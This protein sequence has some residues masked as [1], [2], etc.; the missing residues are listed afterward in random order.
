MY[1]QRTKIVPFFY[2]VEQEKQTKLSLI[3]RITGVGIGIIVLSIGVLILCKLSGLSAWGGTVGGGLFS[4][5]GGL[6]LLSSVCLQ[7]IKKGKES[8]L[9]LPETERSRVVEL[10]HIDPQISVVD[11]MQSENQQENPL[12]K[13][14]AGVS[15]TLET[16]EEKTTIILSRTDM[17]SEIQQTERSRVVE[18]IHI[19]PQI[20]VV[21][22]MQSENQQENPLVKQT[23]GVSKTLETREEKTTI[24]LSRTDVKS[25]IQRLNELWNTFGDFFVELSE[26][27]RLITQLFYINCEQGFL[28]SEQ[29]FDAQENPSSFKEIF[30]QYLSDFISTKQLLPPLERTNWPS[31]NCAKNI[32]NAVKKKIISI[33]AT[34]EEIFDAYVGYN[35][36]I[37]LRPLK[38]DV[39]ML[40]CG[41]GTC[42]NDKKGQPDVHRDVDTVN[43]ALDTNPSVVCF[44]GEPLQ[45]SFFRERYTLIYDEGPIVIFLKNSRLFWDAC[46]VAL[47]KDCKSLVVIPDYVFKEALQGKESAPSD[48]QLLAEK[49]EL[50][51]NLSHGYCHVGQFYAHQAAIR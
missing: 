21:D 34:K 43:I 44:W 50:R 9:I 30:C 23:A 35:R 3:L 40:G 37:L 13:Q 7:C 17:K 32:C 1:I 22:T 24:I 20:S 6:I 19:D 45:V 16:R 47:K 27:Q 39:L 28:S 51:K 49:E 31:Y 36:L 8:N 25:E 18:L 10:I 14:T 46:S 4:A 38:F 42:R 26:E 12:V 29:N 2:G 11:T 41:L 5:L 15:K 48:Y 33:E